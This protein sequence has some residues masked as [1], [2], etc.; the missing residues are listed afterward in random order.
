M[1]VAA[2]ESNFGDYSNGLQ[3]IDSLSCLQNGQPF[4]HIYIGQLFGLDCK[5]FPLN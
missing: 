2:T 5:N 4:S 3:W 1:Y